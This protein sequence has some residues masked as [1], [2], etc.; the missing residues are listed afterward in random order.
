MID[1]TIETEI[2]R[3]P[4]EVFAFA[5][6]PAQLPRWQTNAVS[7]VPEEPGPLRVGSRLREVHRGP[8]GREIES[9]VE[10]SALE[11]DRAFALRMLEGPLPVDADLHFEPAG[12]GTRLRFRVHGQPGGAKRLLQPLLRLALK[13]QFRQHCEDLKRVLEEQDMVTGR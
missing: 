1:F 10:V 2:A 8:G 6:D 3:P 7:A 9:L 11:P 13:R 4:E 5:T 12:A